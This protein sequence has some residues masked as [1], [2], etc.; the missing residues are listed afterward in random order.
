MK[1]AAD[2]KSDNPKGPELDEFNKL[3]Q[4]YDEASAEERERLWPNL[5]RA[6]RKID[7]SFLQKFERCQ[8]PPR[9]DP[10][11]PLRTDPA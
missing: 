10:G 6:I 2:N 1:K 4:K 9:F 7:R 11:F 8:F 5:I 3:Q